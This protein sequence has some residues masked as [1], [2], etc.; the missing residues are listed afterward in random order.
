MRTINIPS[1]PVE[2]LE[3]MLRVETR[4]LNNWVD[5]MAVGM[6]LLTPEDQHRAAARLQARVSALRA[7]LYAL[8]GKAPATLDRPARP[9]RTH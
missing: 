1:S 9:Y 3:E 7:A 5:G 6:E 4:L 2:A 8:R